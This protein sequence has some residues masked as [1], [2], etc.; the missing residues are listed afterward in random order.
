MKNLIIITLLMLMQFAVADELTVENKSRSISATHYLETFDV[1]EYLK[2][3]QQNNPARYSELKRLDAEQ[4]RFNKFNIQQQMFWALDLTDLNDPEFYQ[5]TA[6]LRSNIGDSVR[7]WIED[8]SWNNGYV[9]NSVLNSLV[10][11]LVNGTPPGSIDPSKGILNITGESFGSRPDKAGDGYLNFLILDIKDTFDPDGG[12]RAFVGGYFFPFDQS[13]QSMSNR[14]DLLYLDSFPGIFSPFTQELRTE[15]VLATT[16]H[17]VQHLIHYNYDANEETWLNESMSELASFLCGYSPGNPTLYLGETSRSLT[18]W[19]NELDDYSRVG[20]W[21]VYLFEQFG[22]DFTRIL[23]QDTR[24]G[25]SGL[26][27][28][29]Q[30]RGSGFEETFR[31][32]AIAN[33]VNNTQADPRF[34]YVDE[35]YRG[36][37]AEVDETILSFPK[38]VEADYDAYGVSYFRL[39]GNGLLTLSFSSTIDK[40][41]LIQDAETC[42]S[43]T[44]L[45]GD[46]VAFNNFNP[47]DEFYLIVYGSSAGNQG[48]CAWAEQ[49]LAGQSDVYDTGNLDL[50]INGAIAVAN[51]FRK[52]N[53]FDLTEINFQNTEAGQLS[54]QFYSDGGGRPGN[55]VGTAIDTLIDSDNS[56]VRIIPSEV[57]NNNLAP[58]EVFYVSVSSGNTSFP[59][60]YENAGLD[61]NNS[62]IFRDTSEGWQNLAN[63]QVD[64]NRLAGNWMIRA[65]YTGGL[66]SSGSPNCVKEEFAGNLQI[67]NLYP[68]PTISNLTIPME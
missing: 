38:Q 55:L 24:N 9:D 11:G 52:P 8:E 46:S 42:V 65:F 44:E 56:V 62:F 34:G 59:Y 18:V 32:F 41:Y 64:G 20:L 30:S 17:E 66:I 68:N 60:A 61:N 26:N 51:R 5:T 28:L 14:Q 7:I 12:N 58:G 23:T 21:S 31:N 4:N 29:L 36:L 40:A 37:S 19:D 27:T 49:S 16:A 35:S 3:L 48:I 25:I 22:V 57:V 2:D 63:F 1:A 15:S 10:S 54:I 33:I 13:N 47:D 6:T 45:T 67:M 39:K 43:I 50:R 53:G